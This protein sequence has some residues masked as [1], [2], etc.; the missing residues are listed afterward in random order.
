MCLTTKKCKCPRHSKWDKTHFMTWFQKKIKKR[1]AHYNSITHRAGESRLFEL[2]NLIESISYLIRTY[3]NLK[4][5]NTLI[6]YVMSCCVFFLFF[7]HAQYTIQFQLSH[8]DYY[9]YANFYTL[10]WNNKFEFYVRTKSVP[11]SNRECQGVSIPLLY[12]LH[13]TYYKFCLAPKKALKFQ[14]NVTQ[15][16][17]E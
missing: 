17:F 10:I 2:Y 8:K 12:C 11:G 13:F 1:N 7:C 16:N 6:L 3:T 14:T 15:K 4:K 5:K 9:S